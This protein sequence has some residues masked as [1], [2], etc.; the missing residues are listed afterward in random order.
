MNQP[1][2]NAQ[3][4][5]LALLLIV[6]LPIGLWITAA[7]TFSAGASDPADPPEASA[8]AACDQ[9]PPEPSLKTGVLLV[10]HGSRSASWRE[11][12]L[13]LHDDV[14]P[15]LSNLPEVAGVKSAFM[16]YA[17]PS[18]AT[19]LKQFD[20]EGYD[21]VILVPLLLT[22]SS[23]SFDD[24]PTIIGAKQDA[25][26]LATLE[27]ERI[28]R[29]TPRAEVAITPLL[30]FSELLQQNVPRRVKALSR[31][32]AQEAV[33]LV[34]YGDEDY[35]EQWQQVFAELDETVC[36]QTAAAAATH[37][38][39][40]HIV[41]YSREP[42]KQAIRDMLS[43]HQRAVVIPVLVARDEAFQDQL[44]GKAIEE[45]AAGDRVAYVPDAIL[46]DP[47]LN[48]WIVQATRQAMT[49]PPALGPASAERRP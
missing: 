4:R 5:S 13:E 33:V 36:R 26:S 42:T 17:E 41:R 43:K 12:L 48:D 30:D 16:E 28:E 24:I 15:R 22:V 6:A 49:K 45:L 44:I 10:S 2:P 37:C 7:R 39:C 20:Q 19:Q 32:P 1:S 3:F 40:G 29:Y 14:A 21:R 35:D 47:K 25:H 34:A 27:A 8:A 23:H 11:M 38:W 31:D 9:R 46:P 18:I